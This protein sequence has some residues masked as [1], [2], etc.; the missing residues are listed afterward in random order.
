MYQTVFATPDIRVDHQELLL[1]AAMAHRRVWMRY[2]TA[3][4]QT[5]SE[6]VVEPFVLHMHPHGLHLIA[7]C[8]NRQAFVNFNVNLIEEVR[9]LDETFAPADRSFDRAAFLEVGFDGHYSLPV[10]DVHLL[11]RPPTAHWARDR[12]FHPTQTVVDRPDGCVEVRFIS[13]GQEAIAARVLG[14]GEDCQVIEPESLRQM[15]T[16]RAE[17]LLA[18]YR[19][20]E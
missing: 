19:E 12:F 2:F 8:L 20:K 9:V 3:V 4:R 17:A 1:D 15:V 16:Q 5:S 13:G 18:R 14:L 11:I 7:Y 10:V 6:R